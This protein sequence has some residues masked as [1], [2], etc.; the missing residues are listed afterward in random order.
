MTLP[1]Y[2]CL[3]DTFIAPFMFYKG[4][5]IE[6]AAPPGNHLQPLNAEA[7]ARMEDWYNE[8]HEEVNE[9]TGEKTGKMF[10]PHWKFRPAVYVPGAQA[11]AKLLKAPAKDD[12][13]G[14]L[15]L[16]TAQMSQQLN[17]DQRPGPE[18][19]FEDLDDDTLIAEQNADEV[20]VLEAAPRPTMAQRGKGL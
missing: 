15:N 20:R 5:V 3:Q 4:S 9:R 2:R 18:M 14:V 11:S 1:K 8:E 19:D 17:T 12:M 10:K 13:T 7:K 16:A 6:S